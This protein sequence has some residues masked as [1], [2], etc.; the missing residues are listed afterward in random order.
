[1]ALFIVCVETHVAHG[2]IY[3]SANVLSWYGV[4][5]PIT[6]THTYSVSPWTKWISERPDGSLYWA[7]LVDNLLPLIIFLTHRVGTAYCLP[8]HSCAVM[9]STV[10]WRRH[11]VCLPV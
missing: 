8:K 1:L 11:N 10:D 2:G 4:L 7:A 5:M 3:F 6:K 9:Y